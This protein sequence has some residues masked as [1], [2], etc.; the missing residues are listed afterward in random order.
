MFAG[1]ETAELLAYWHRAEQRARDF[2]ERAKAER[3]A[4]RAGGLRESRQFWRYESELAKIELI[5]R[6][7]AA[8]GQVT[9]DS[10]D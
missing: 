9:G 8:V 4:H 5:G 7:S 3:R 10:D 2:A 1:I 6:L